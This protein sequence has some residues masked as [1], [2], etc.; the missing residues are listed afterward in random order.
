MSRYRPPVRPGSK[1]ITPEGERRLREELDQLWRVQRPQ[2]TRAVQEAA[3]QG[4]RY[5]LTQFSAFQMAQQ[6]LKTQ[7][8]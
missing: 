1:F 8:A 6:L 4:D 7:T 3:A 5:N 2:V